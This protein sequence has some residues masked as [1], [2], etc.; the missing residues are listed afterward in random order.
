MVV[1]AALITML[2]ACTSSSHPTDH[3]TPRA[4]PSA[5][6]SSCEV[7]VAESAVT[8][9]DHYAV[10]ARDQLNDLFLASAILENPCRRTATNVRFVVSPLDDQG[11][12]LMSAG[13]PVQAHFTIS[14]IMPGQRAAGWAYFDRKQAPD[15]VANLRVQL[16]T[17]PF[18]GEVCWIAPSTS[19]YQAAGRATDVTVGK[20]DTSRTSANGLARLSFKVT[21]SPTKSSPG[22]RAASVIFRDSSGRLLNANGQGIGPALKPGQRVHFDAWVPENADPSRT[23][24]LLEP[25]PVTPGLPFYSPSSSCLP[26]S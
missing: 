1:V 12:E 13:R 11:H 3:R 19:G 24:V 18:G 8:R 26:S 16:D 23:G 20:R 22:R 25:N 21:W 4:Q 10:G 17:A 15:G 7:R 2:V 6:G 14:L 9:K 5:H